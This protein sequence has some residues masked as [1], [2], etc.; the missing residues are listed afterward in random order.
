[1]S[2]LPAIQVK[3][4]LTKLRLK[5]HKERERH[6]KAVKKLQAAVFDLQENGCPHETWSFNPDPSGNNDSYYECDTCGRERHR[7]P[8]C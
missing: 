1:M 2:K 8:C 4:K 7:R 3:E 6:D 5:L